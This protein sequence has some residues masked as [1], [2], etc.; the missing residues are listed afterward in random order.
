MAVVGQASTCGLT[1]NIS[2]ELLQESCE[3]LT[4][5]TVPKLFVRLRLAHIVLLPSNILPIM[6]AKS[7]TV[8]GGVRS[9]IDARE[10]LV[11]AGPRSPCLPCPRIS[12]LV[13]RTEGRHG[14]LPL[15]PH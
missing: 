11:G 6:G 15:R 7:K 12:I 8:G 14:D 13:V 2:R 9:K 4:R 1:P 5:I 10:K 3:S